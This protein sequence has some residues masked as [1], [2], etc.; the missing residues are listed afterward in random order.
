MLYRHAFLLMG[1]VSADQPDD[2]YDYVYEETQYEGV[3][4]LS[5]NHKDAP[6]PEPMLNGECRQWRN[7]SCCMP[8]L[9]QICS[10][11]ISNGIF[12]NR[13]SIYLDLKQ[14]KQN[15][16]II[17]VAKCLNSVWSLCIV[18]GVFISVILI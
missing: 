10:R 17:I 18:N 1:F 7:N 3:C 6:S 16:N 14:Q 4:V 12:Q 2:Q 9:I 15:S 5:H 11:M 13:I 8:G